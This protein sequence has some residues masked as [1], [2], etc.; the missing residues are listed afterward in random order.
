[1]FAS[2]L[3]AL[4]AV[5]SSHRYFANKKHVHDHIR[6][7]KPVNCTLGNAG[8]TH[9]WISAMNREE[10]YELQITNQR[11]YSSLAGLCQLK[12]LATSWV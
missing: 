7:R 5:M 6:R 11:T 12:R 2:E 10:N 4:A 1:M 8:V 3:V 9:I